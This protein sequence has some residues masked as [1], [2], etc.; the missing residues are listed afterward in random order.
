MFTINQGLLAR[1]TEAVKEGD[2]IARKTGQIQSFEVFRNGFRMNLV[3]GRIMIVPPSVCDSKEDFPVALLY[4]ALVREIRPEDLSD[5]MSSKIGESD[6]DEYDT[7]DMSEIKD[8]LFRV[9]GSKKYTSLV[10][11]LPSWSS[12]REYIYF[13]YTKDE[14]ALE[15]AVRHLVFGAYYDPRFSS[16]FNRIMEDTDTTDHGHE[17]DVAN[18]TP[19][20]NFPGLAEGAMHEYP[21]LQ[22]ADDAEASQD[23]PTGPDSKKKKK[24]SANKPKMVI[25]TKTAAA[26]D[27][28]DLARGEVDV[29]SAVTEA[30]EAA[31]LN[32]R[33]TVSEV[34][35]D[36]NA[37]KKAASRKSA[38]GQIPCPYCKHSFANT[39]D[40]EDH[41]ARAHKNASDESENDK[42]KP[43][44]KGIT[45]K[46]AAL[47]CECA[48]PGCPYHAGVGH[49]NQN[50]AGEVFRVDMEDETGTPMCEDCAADALD[51]GVFTTREEPMEL[52]EVGAG[53]PIRLSSDKTADT[54]D[55]PSNEKGGEGA[56]EVKTETEISNT[57]G[58]EPKMAAQDRAARIAELE[59]I[60]R[61]HEISEANGATPQLDE[62]GA[63]KEDIATCGNC[64]LSWNDALISSMT[65]TPSGRCPYEYIHPEIKELKRLKRGMTAGASRD[66]LFIASVKIASKK[67]RYAK[68]KNAASVEVRVSEDKGDM[69]QT[70]IN[71]LNERHAAM[72]AANPQGF[73]DQFESQLGNI[74][75]EIGQEMG[76]KVREEAGE[77]FIF[78]DEAGAG[79]SDEQ[80]SRAFASQKGAAG[81]KPGCA[82]G[83][84]KNKGKLPGAD[85][86]DDKKEEKE[87]SGDEELNGLDE[88][89]NRKKKEAA[90]KGTSGASQLVTGLPHEASDKLVIANLERYAVSQHSAGESTRTKAARKAHEEKIAVWR[91][92]HVADESDDVLAEASKPFGKPAEVKVKDGDGRPD[93]ATPKLANPT[94]WFVTDRAED[95]EAA[96]DLP[97]LEIPESEPVTGV[98]TQ[99]TEG[100][101]PV[102]KALQSVT[103]EVKAPADLGESKATDITDPLDLNE[104]A[105][106]WLGD[107]S[108]E[109][110]THEAPSEEPAEEESHEEEEP[111]EAE[112]KTASMTMKC[113]DCKGQA[114]KEEHGKPYNCGCGWKSAEPKTSS[115]KKASAKRADRIIATLDDLLAAEPFDADNETRP[116]NSLNQGLVS[117]PIEGGRHETNDTAGPA[118][119]VAD[120]DDVT[121]ARP[122]PNCHYPGNTVEPDTGNCRACRQHVMEPFGKSFIEERFKKKGELTSDS[123][124][125]PNKNQPGGVQ[126]PGPSN[127][128]E[129]PNINAVR[130]QVEVTEEMDKGESVEEKQEEI[131]AIA[132]KEEAELEAPVEAAE[133]AT[134]E[135]V[136]APAGSGKIV[137]NINAAQKWLKAHGILAEKEDAYDAEPITSGMSGGA[138]GGGF[139]AETSAPAIGEEVP[140]E[141]SITAGPLAD[142]QQQFFSDAGSQLKPHM[143][144]LGDAAGAGE[145]AGADAAELALIASTTKKA[146]RGIGPASTP[147]KDYNGWHNWETW[148]T[149]LLIDNDQNLHNTYRNLSANAIKRA[150]GGEVNIARL[151]DQ[152]SKVLARAKDETKAF[153][154]QNAREIP[155]SEWATQPFEEIDWYTIAAHG[156]E[157]AQDDLAADQKQTP[158]AAAPTAAVK[159]ASTEKEAGFNFFFP[160]QVLKEFY[161]EVQH[162]V[163]DYPNA[164][165]HPMIQDVDLAPSKVGSVRMEAG[166]PGYVSTDPAAAMGIGR[167]GKAQVLEG[168]PLRKE[169]DIRGPMFSDE[170]YANYPGIP[171]KALA[172][173]GSRKEF[174]KRAAASADQKAMLSDFL[175]QIMGEIAATFIAA[176]KV[177]SR[178][179]ELDKV[180]GRGEISLMLIEQG[181]ATMP[182]YAV[183]VGGRIKFL[184]EKMNDSDIQDSINDAWSQAAVWHDGSAAGNYTYEVFVRAESI[185]TDSLTLKYSFVTGTKGDVS[186]A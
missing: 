40:L 88:V 89:M 108:V 140:E 96:S 159:D 24:A 153:Y 132:A 81:H 55:N 119:K 168:A 149:K 51:S 84:C 38:G 12:P 161:P 72:K 92:T 105:A 11:F 183:E 19:K 44:I 141:M 43:Y 5:M 173:Q 160:G 39:D 182:G 155:G 68:N 93:G 33:E 172:M 7:A 150:K 61:E 65:P 4:G 57:R 129:R 45:E 63:V 9:P 85:K 123:E 163:V 117:G 144:S 171:G 148:H 143:P 122:C 180:P 86:G 53:A 107:E 23:R 62:N 25:T 146:E 21:D 147:S 102:G 59:D 178:P 29:I 128:S 95:G 169:N 179:L 115:P 83:F 109:E 151:A 26:L 79:L 22:S 69:F 60:I 20:L 90:G 106:R 111:K 103:T 139:D 77:Q 186:G 32:K 120:K 98:Y 177:T 99:D 13:K 14:A 18:I 116:H 42:T 170:F 124:V 8:K 134:T 126:L 174:K 52:E 67:V 121:K 166:V 56:I 54:A 37:A 114:E 30:A 49:C 28:D 176:F 110:E 181:A 138:F 50:A 94:D 80:A 82:C 16:A 104:A 31:L 158:P 162:E 87:A 152:M 97:Q 58:T 71:K 167:D 156:V 48:D 78:T 70:I 164:D 133:E 75:L 154:E 64:G 125:A 46:K 145:G 34:A 113:P 136:D 47:I 66:R 165:N 73:L 76:L 6:F 91:R 131:E 1:C 100:K 118:N 112:V 2:A 135:V 137:I 127:T 184:L 130:E 27:A 142:A 17:L 15:N 157:D 35:E 74:M 41:E 36:D 101:D 175:K 10:L 185:D 3:I